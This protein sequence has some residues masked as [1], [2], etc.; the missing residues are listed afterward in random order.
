[1][2][3]MPRD[4]RNGIGGLGL[5][6]QA[7]ARQPR[8]MPVTPSCRHALTALLVV[9]ITA[10]AAPVTADPW[11]AP[12]DIR[13]RHDL[14]LLA[15]AGIVKAP[16][17]SWPVSWAEVARDLASADFEPRPEHVAAALTRVRGQALDA[18]R[19]GEPDAHVRVAGSAEPMA[20]R[21]F[22]AVPREEG[23]IEAGLQYT[24]EWF[25]ARLQATAVADADDG[26]S[27]RP[28]G[29][30]V[31]AVLG[32]WIISAGWIDRWWGPGWEGSL[33]YGNNSR[34]IPSLTLER[35]YSDAFEHP[36]LKWIGQWRLAVTMGQL[37]GDR[38]DA[39]DAQLFGMRVTW[40]PHPRVEV[41]ISRAAQWC[42]E[43]RPCDAG[44]FWDLLIGNDND[45]PEEEQ[46][47]NQ[48]AGFDVR[49][50]VPGAPVALYAQLI[51]EDEAGYLPSKYLGLMGAETW[52]GW[53]DRSW[54][55]HV[56]Y[57]DTVCSFTRSPPEYGCA[58]RHSIY[59]DG[60]QYR[61]RSIG[62]GLDGDSEQWALGAVLVNADGSS[63]EFAAQDARINRASAN[64]V[65][66]VA[67]FA[68]K[69]RS[70]DVYHRRMLLGGDLSLGLGYEQRDLVALGQE[71]DDLRGFA[72]WTRRFQ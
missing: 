8:G 17:T 39:P 29:S 44:T 57:A 25:A 38:D 11:A 2:P 6:L 43:G 52:G 1:M 70:A 49:W 47:G 48:M 21:R 4:F 15:D 10:S 30:Y 37:E 58:Y 27:V 9:C 46:P 32:N 20:L 28:D 13:L 22:G 7:W 14:Q 23:E 60:Y 45:Q 61:D 3:T 18:M 69:I 72:E 33:I 50:S 59:T 67:P 66:S 42:G 12:G 62:H 68:A 63:L 53:G 26:K 65:H 54:R 64:P 71:S 5:F 24:G 35:N 36:W 19:V 34:P 16:L 31:G 55:V 56:E 51:G 41:G 40:K